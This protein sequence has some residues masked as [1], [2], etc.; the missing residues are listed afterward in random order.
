MTGADE[1]RISKTVNNKKKAGLAATPVQDQLNTI[2]VS[3]SGHTDKGTIAQAVKHM[4]GKD[5]KLIRE[6]YRRVVPNV[7]LRSDFECRS[8]GASTEMEV[9]LSV[10]FFWAR[11]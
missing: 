5:S 7:E 4:T 6:S 9:P 2:I 3:V 8:C 11:T 10:D 1:N